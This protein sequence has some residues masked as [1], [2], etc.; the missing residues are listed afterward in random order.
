MD[1]HTVSFTSLAEKGTSR[2]WRD[3]SLYQQSAISHHLTEDM[4]QPAEST[5][6][7]SKRRAQILGRIP[8]IGI[9]GAGLAGLRCADVLL[10]HGFNVTLIEGRNRLGG[11]VHQIPLTPGLLVEYVMHIV[12]YMS[13]APFVS[14][15]CPT[16]HSHCVQT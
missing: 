6:N 13:W 8:R 12:L 4:P 3:L 9:I 14:K 1:A 11:R 5:I 7:I 15:I 16:L 10:Q 2:I